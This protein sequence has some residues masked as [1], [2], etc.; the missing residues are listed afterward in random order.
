MADLV[1]V[2]EDSGY[3]VVYSCL[4]NVV[5]GDDDCRDCD[6]G[7]VLGSAV[8][9]LGDGVL[10]VVGAGSDQAVDV[11]LIEGDEVDLLASAEVLNS[12]SGSACN[13]E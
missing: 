4:G 1:D 11:L 8:N 10:F 7:N 2:I 5:A 6:G 13:D 3:E 9:V 12:G